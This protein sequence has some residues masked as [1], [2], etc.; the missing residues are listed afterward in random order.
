MANKLINCTVYNI[1]IKK[2]INYRLKT[3]NKK[4]FI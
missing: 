4:I 1:T 2:I 3:N